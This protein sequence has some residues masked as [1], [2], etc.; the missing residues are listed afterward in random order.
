MAE[1]PKKASQELLSAATEVKNIQGDYNDIIKQSI[2]NLNSVSKAYGNIQDKLNSLSSGE[3]NIVKIQSE[4]YKAKV[5]QSGA[6]RELNNLA[7]ELN[8][9]GEK[10][11]AGANKFKEAIEQRITAEE[12]G[13]SLSSIKLDKK[14]EKLQKSLTP[15]QVS[16]ALLQ[17]SNEEAQKAVLL[18]EEQLKKEKEI[19]NSIG[20]G[21]AAI[22]L[23]ADKLG[24]GDKV[25]SAM[26][27]KA[28]QLNEEGK[29][30]SKL[31]TFKA[32]VGAGISSAMDS[33]TDPLVFIPMIGTVVSAIAKG[34]KAALDFILEIDDRTTKFAR[35]LGVSKDEASAISERFGD[36]STN[37]GNLLLTTK[38]LQEAQSDLVK[39][40]GV[41]NILSDEMLETQI[42]LNK[43]MGLTTDEMGSLAEASILSGKAQKQVVTGIL[44]QVAS[45]KSATGIAFN[46]KQIIGEASKLGGV[47]GLKFAKYPESLT[48]SLVA[49]KALGM[50]LAKVDQIAGSL[51]NFEDSIQNQLEAQL[52]TGKDINLSRAQ[53]LALEGDTAGVA[54]ELSKAI[55]N[56]NEFLKM[57]RIQQ[58]SIAKAVG[59]SREDIGETLKKQEMLSKLGAKDIKEAQ[60]KVELLK[61]QGKTQKEIAALLGEEAYQNLTQLS[62]Q[63][64]IAELI[65]KVKGAFQDFVQKSGIVDYIVGIIDYLTNPDN[66]KSLINTIKNGVAM[67]AD[68]IQ[69]ITYGIL[70]VVSIFSDK[71]DD[72][73]DKVDRDEVGN[74][75]DSIRDTGTQ[76]AEFKDFI[77]KPL[78]ED[79]ITMAGG[80]KLGRT[81]EMVD[82]LKQILGETKQGKV[83]SLN[84]DGAP[85]ATAVARNAPMNPSASN[86]GPRPLR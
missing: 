9:L 41:T 54:Q 49:T 45:L 52:L 59:M 33:L 79:T 32:G 65:E 48:K 76:Q 17:K 37:S 69:T 30:A 24:V 25:Y 67:V 43:V 74:W 31:Q 68:I 28:R 4:L 12:K 47:L 36:I 3:L 46:Y 71:A 20:L 1:D 40:L 6:Q 78:G 18:A 61:A 58:E 27:D 55:G 34:L 39:E 73:L 11:I 64:K 38:N 81:D 66:V 23:F 13:D 72:L 57:N 16:Y 10:G 44:G 82:L 63:E 70:S 42:S 19:K 5:K 84:I 21:G 15:Q 14:I 53:Q 56:S 85:V 8:K 80:T 62:A 50:D 75:G 35:T 7:G 22:K 26:V 86:L 60:A 51:L 77:I 29:K 83:M 2:Q